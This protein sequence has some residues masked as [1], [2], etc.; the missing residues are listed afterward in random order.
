MRCAGIAGMPIWLL[1]LRS[2]G[3]LMAAIKTGS[4]HHFFPLSFRTVAIVHLVV[5]KAGVLNTPELK[6]ER[7]ETPVFRRHG[8]LNPNSRAD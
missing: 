1:A 7:R 3:A 8:C 2:R 6:P 4:R 5:E